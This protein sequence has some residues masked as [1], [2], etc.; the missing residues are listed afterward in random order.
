M[1]SRLREI[2]ATRSRRSPRRISLPDGISIGIIRGS[3]RCSKR[4]VQV[5]WGSL[6]T[7]QPPQVAGSMV[8][9]SGGTLI[10]GSE[11]A[12]W[13]FPPWAVS[14]FPIITFH[15]RTIV[16]C[17]PA[18]HV[19][20]RHCTTRHPEGLPDVSRICAVTHDRHSLC[21]C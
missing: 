20:S 15:R 4:Y 11:R 2:G 8:S 6:T 3:A 16:A 21:I 13:L 10:R 14:Y 9:N 1:R 5:D 19:V 18:F 12:A 17:G 7:L